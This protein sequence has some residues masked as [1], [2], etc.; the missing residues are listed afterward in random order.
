MTLLILILG[1]KKQLHHI[2]SFSYNHANSFRYTRWKIFMCKK[3]LKIETN[4]SI[5]IV[6][7][8]Q[9]FKKKKKPGFIY[10]VVST[11]CTEDCRIYKSAL[12]QNTFSRN[13]GKK[14]WLTIW[15]F[16]VSKT[17]CRFSKP[18]NFLL[19]LVILILQNY[20]LKRRGAESPIIC[21]S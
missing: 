2:G 3:E 20:F 13:I 9:S 5:T 8:S 1:S 17:T 7:P 12:I 21:N 11:E 16:T 4:C 19:A 14:S 6:I 18:V 15:Y 10:T